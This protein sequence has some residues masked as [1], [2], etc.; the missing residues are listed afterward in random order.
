MYTIKY[1]INIKYKFKHLNIYKI[2][3][4]VYLNLIIVDS[5]MND[6]II[7]NICK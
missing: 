5:E 4:L 3:I 1:E 6:N 2:S 7:S